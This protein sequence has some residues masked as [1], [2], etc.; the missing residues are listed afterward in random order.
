MHLICFLFSSGIGRTGAFIVID[1][2]VKILQK[3]GNRNNLEHVL[4]I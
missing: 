1:I 3:Q 2:L 4:M